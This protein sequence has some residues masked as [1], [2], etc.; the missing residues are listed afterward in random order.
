MMKLSP[1]PLLDP[2]FRRGFYNA[3]ILSL[4]AVEAH[5]DQLDRWAD[6]NAAKKDYSGASSQQKAAVDLHVAVALIKEALVPHTHNHPGFRSDLGDE[7]PGCL[8]DEYQRTSPH[9]IGESNQ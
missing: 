8:F 4:R 3:I 2:Q 5:V 9:D 7:C 6:E 1:D